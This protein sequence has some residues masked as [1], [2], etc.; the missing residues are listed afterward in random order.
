MVYQE[1][2]NIKFK[3]KEYF[4]FS[5]LH[6]FGKVFKVFDD[7]DSGNICFGVN[8]GNE[9]LFIKFAGAPTSEY[10]GEPIDA[11]NTLKSTV[12]LYQTIHHKCL[13][14]YIDSFEIS[15]G[16][17]MIFKWADGKCMGRMYDSHKEIMALPIKTKLKIFSDITIFVESI[18]NQGYI[19][20]DFYDGSIMYDTITEKTTICDIDYFRKLPTKN[21]MGKMF[22]S[23][24]FLSP[25]EKVLGAELDETT[26]VYTLGQMA[27]SLFT[28]S[29]RKKENWVLNR[30][31][32]DILTKAIS[33]EKRNRYRTIKEFSDHWNMAL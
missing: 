1:I 10:S 22:G 4:D 12:P 5:F 16:F 3:M 30:E 17:A 11:I 21:D 9:K 29:D 15:N 24:R 25:E 18:I 26:N 32:Y 19:A 14:E 7:Q 28:D 20:V 27:F 13:I 2:D 33:P 6:K 31:S 8:N 23:D